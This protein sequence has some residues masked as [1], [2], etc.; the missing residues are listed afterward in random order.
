MSEIK[1]NPPGRRFLERSRRGISL[2]M[3]MVTVTALAVVTSAILPQLVGQL[4]SAQDAVDLTEA[5]QAAE[6]GAN[7][8]IAW[9]NHRM[10]QHTWVD[11]DPNSGY[12]AEY[13]A[14][15]GNYYRVGVKTVKADGTRVVVAEGTCGKLRRLLQVEAQV[16]KRSEMWNYAI[17][18]Q[19]S[20]DIGGSVNI[21]SSP[22]TGIGNVHSNA[23]VSL[24]GAISVDGDVTATGTVSGGGSVTGARESGTPAVTLPPVDFTALK[25]QAASLGVINGN[26]TATPLVPLQGVINGDLT[27]KSGVNLTVNNIVWVTG[28]LDLSG[29]SA[30]SVGT[31]A[32]VVEGTITMTGGTNTDTGSGA[33]NLTLICLSTSPT[34]VRIAGHASLKAGLYVPYGGVELRGTCDILGSISAKT[35]DIGGNSSITRDTNFAPPTFFG[36]E[37][38]VLDWLEL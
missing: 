24:R 23:D 13:P 9:C 20:I 30:V 38:H 19:D 34:A 11:T 27:L 10:P 12:R 15:S 37:A 6:A 1:K 18:T 4:R 22:L 36:G 29:T 25:A 26:V 16:D 21:D 5:L 17:F 28:N 7:W 3:V 8:E 35:M 2:L 33:S 31:G 14:G 32:I